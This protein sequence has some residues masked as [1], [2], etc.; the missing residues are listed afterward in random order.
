[1]TT[2]RL[3]PTVLPDGDDRDV[4]IADGAFT[5][6]PVD[7]AEPL[8][9]RYALPGLVDAHA[10]L[11]IDMS[12]TGLDAG[13]DALVA[14]NLRAQRDAGVLLLRDVGR[15]RDEP[16]RPGDDD[17]EVAQAGRFLGPENG[18]VEGLHVATPPDRVLDAVRAQVASGVRWVKVVGDWK[19]GGEIRL[20]YE[21]ALLRDVADLAH[22]NGVRLAV[23]AL[24]ADACRAAVECGAD[25]VEHGFTLDDDLLRAMA[26]R[27]AAWTPT[28]SAATSP[29]P[30]DAPA[31][32]RRRQTAWLDNLR[33][34]LPRAAAHGVRVLAGTD[35]VPHGSIAGE[36]AL[37]VEF[38]LDPV[39]ALRAATTSAREFLGAPGIEDGA[40][41]DVVTY[42][43][44]P[45]DDPEVLR[46]PAA[47][48]RRGVRVR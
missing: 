35:T 43:A 46:S 18:W 27:G 5:T 20:N 7:G 42:D 32:S 31:E 10:H 37:L 45:R 36:V 16:L 28:L 24:G 23:H 13:S 17:P 48:V 30:P 9:G 34:T 14:A 22:A 15:V 38:G 4:W 8:P 47:V 33:A 6:S 44:D 25:T 1:M 39:A 41:A 21:P 40:P 11:T 3:P 12:G 2:L 19:H 26:A 29:P